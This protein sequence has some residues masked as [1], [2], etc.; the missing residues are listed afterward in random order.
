MGISIRISLASPEADL[1]AAVRPGV[2]TILY[3]R[4]ESA[5]QIQQADVLIT[6]LERRRGIRPGTVELR[7][8]IESPKG[9]SMAHDI[10]SSSPRLVAIG[11]GPNVGVTLDGD[12]LGYASGECELHALASGLTPLNVQYVLD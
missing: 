10:A 11:V 2:T 1:A 9:V 3:P 7:A 8:L 4:V 12:A 6:E 5:E